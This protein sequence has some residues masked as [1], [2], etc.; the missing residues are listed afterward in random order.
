MAAGID[1]QQRKPGGAEYRLA[2]GRAALFSE[3]DALMKQ[4]WLV[5]AD[6][7]SRQGQ[8]EERIYLA[9]EFDPALLD[10][11][12]SE[13]VSVIDQLDWDEREGVLRAERQRKVGE[14]VLSLEPLTG[15]DETARTQALVNLVAVLDG[16]LWLAVQRAWGD[17]PA[18][19]AKLLR[20]D[21]ASGEWAGVLYPLEAA[22]S[23]WVGLSELALHGD[24][25]YLIER[26]NQ[27]GEA[28]QLKAVTRGFTVAA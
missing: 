7:G 16:K 28:A 22:G 3:V 14:L 13:Q 10:D 25:L 21:P 20:L 17:D 4:P 9:A 5:I 11:V 26:D 12:L 6:L 24:A 23:G 15:L 18:D 1:E 27:I 8:R 19:H 2:N